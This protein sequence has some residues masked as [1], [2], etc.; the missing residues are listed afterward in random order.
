MAYDTDLAKRIRERLAE[1]PGVTERAMFGGLAFMANGNMVLG[2]VKDVLIVRV[3]RDGYEDALREPEAGPMTFTGHSM[4]G[5]V[6]V[7]VA[8]LDDDAVL[9]RWIRRGLDFA[10]SLPPK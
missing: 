1:M 3:G 9:D 6:Q 4:R 10:L 7:D 5:F 8:S 2:P